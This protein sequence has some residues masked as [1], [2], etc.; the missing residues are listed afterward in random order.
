MRIGS[1]ARA[2]MGVS[3]G[4]DKIRFPSPVRT[5]SRVR[6]GISVASVA[7]V[8]RHRPVLAAGHALFLSD[9]G[10]HGTADPER[11]TP[12]HAAASPV[13]G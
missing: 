12:A 13:S 10:S 9:R 4:L 8:A 7:K 11:R 6:A 2:A 1:S 3:Y 5:G